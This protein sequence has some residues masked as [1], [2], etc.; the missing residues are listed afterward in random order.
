MPEPALYP[1]GEVPDLTL[2]DAGYASLHP[3]IRLD[4]A[5]A[6]E[7]A[8]RSIPGSDAIISVSSE[9]SDSFAE[10][11]LIHSDGFSGERAGTSFWNGV[12]VSVKDRDGKKPR[13]WNWVG[14]RHFGRLPGLQETGYKAAHRA[15]ARRGARKGESGFFTMVLDNR[16]GGRLVKSMSGPMS[17]GKLYERQSCL[18]GKVGQRVG[19]DLLTVTDNPLMPM[20]LNSRHYDGEGL[21]SRRLPLFS[22]GVLQNYYLDTYYGSKLEMAPTT[23]NSSN[24]EWKLGSKSQAELIRDVGNGILVTSFLG[25]NSNSTT[26]DFSFGISGFMIRDG[27]KAE[28]VSEMNIS[29]NLLDL[30]MNLV[31]VGNDPYTY[32]SMQRPSMYFKDINFSGL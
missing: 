30:W 2:V 10:S 29:G 3:E 13:D 31:E 1:S 32:S 6:L 16:S 11:V 17:G 23:G 4:R 27:I 14:A 7:E 12:V 24:L 22:E 8:A 25:G 15:L 18:E 26:G 20:G 19:S 21:A 9:F 28:P 5:K